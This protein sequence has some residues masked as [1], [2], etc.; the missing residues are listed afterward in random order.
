MGEYVSYAEEFRAPVAQAWRKRSPLYSPYRI[1][2]GSGNGMRIRR[3]DLARGLAFGLSLAAVLCAA[4][5]LSAAEGYAIGLV[6]PGMNQTELQAVMGPPSYI[7]VKGLRQA[8]QYCPPRGFLRMVE[9]LF[10][11]ERD[12]DLYVTVWFDN[13]RVRHMRAYPSRVMGRCEDFLA[14]FRWE[15]EIDGVFAADAYG[16]EGYRIK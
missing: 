13:G 16:Y 15:D 2:R 12:P 7:Q 10:Q 1:T 6:A 8:W 11:R 5:R 14:A 3:T 9:D 4:P